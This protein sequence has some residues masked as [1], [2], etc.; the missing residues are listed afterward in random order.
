VVELEALFFEIF[1]IARV[2]E[3]LISHHNEAR[4]MSTR[5]TNIIQII[6]SDAE[7][8]TDERISR[9]VKFSSNTIRLETINTS[10]DI[11]Y[12]ISPTSN[13][14]VSFNTFARNALSSKS[15]FKTFPSFSKSQNLVL[16]FTETVSNETVLAITTKTRYIK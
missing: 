4:I 14:R 6:K 10:S 8:W 13:N 12:I 15:S 3:N 1:V 2:V 7:L 9:W 5:H 16:I 11:F